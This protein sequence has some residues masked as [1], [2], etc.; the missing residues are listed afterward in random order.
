MPA[1]KAERV[2]ELDAL[3]GFSL[4][5]MILH[6]FIFDLRYLLSLPVF[7]FQES[8]WFI[9][10][11]QPFFLNVFVIVSGICCTF[12][13]NNTRRGLRLL[14]VALAL[15][16]VTWAASIWTGYDF[17]IYFNVLH[18]LSTG[19]LFYALLTRKERKTGHALSRVDVSLSLLSAAII[20]GDSFLHLAEGRG[21]WWLLPIGLPPQ[22]NQSMADYLPLIP[23]LGFFLTG[24][25]IG[26]TVYRERRTAFPGA[27]DWILKAGRPFA[28]LGRHSL[29]IYILHQ[30]ALLAVLFGLRAMG[31]I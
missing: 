18:L 26:R 12:S 30:P 2:F 15:S 13:K 4:F 17:Y 23:W 24:A 29:V 5:L 31:L 11:L 3:R 20:W 21:S 14:L 7:A 9:Y 25:L 19:I 22:M 6:H 28:F 1:I 27:P 16:V 8:W 10:L